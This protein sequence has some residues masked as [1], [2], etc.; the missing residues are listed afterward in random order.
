MVLDQESED[1]LF[2]CVVGWLGRV[3]GVL[4]RGHVSLRGWDRGG[5]E[6]SD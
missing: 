1:G 2:K 6:L 4:K 5:S 3:S